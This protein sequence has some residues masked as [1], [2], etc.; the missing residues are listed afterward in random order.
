M[1]AH[2]NYTFFLFLSPSPVCLGFTLRLLPPPPQEAPRKHSVIYILKR[3]RRVAAEQE[4]GRGARSLGRCFSR[5]RPLSLS[6]PDEISRDGAGAVF[7]VV[8]L[9]WKHGS[10]P[11]HGSSRFPSLPPRPFF[12]CQVDVPLPRLLRP[13]RGDILTISLYFVC[14]PAAAS[15]RRSAAPLRR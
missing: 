7:L 10:R 2:H 14:R 8:Q 11:S 1:A 3:T 6:D 13:P 9:G 4:E 15:L 5:L 12:P